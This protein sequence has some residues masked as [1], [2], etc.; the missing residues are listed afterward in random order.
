MTDMYDPWGVGEALQMSMRMYTH[1]K[2]GTGRSTLLFN[3]LRDNDTV[4][5]CTRQH[6]NQ[7]ELECKKRSVDV[8]ILSQEPNRGIRHALSEV[9]R[10]YNML[11]NLYF[12]HTWFEALYLYQIQDT[13]SIMGQFMADMNKR[14]E[15]FKKPSSPIMFRMDEPSDFR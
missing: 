3:S 6:A 9:S 2:K 10:R 8:T 7:I 15:E 1:S 12:D 13:M 11:G 14:K 4:V 5:V